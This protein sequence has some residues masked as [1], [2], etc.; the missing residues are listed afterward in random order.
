MSTSVGRSLTITYDNVLGYFSGH[1]S[2][3]IHVNSYSNDQIICLSLGD[4]SGGANLTDSAKNI[5]FP[6]S[7]AHPTKAEMTWLVHGI[8]ATGTA[9]LIINGDTVLSGNIPNGD[10]TLTGSGSGSGVKSATKSSTISYELT[11][12]TATLGYV[13]CW[14]GS[15][16]G[17]LTLY[18]TR[19]DYSASRGTGISLAVPLSKSLV[20]GSVSGNTGGYS[21][22][23]NG[24]ISYT[25]LDGSSCVA[26][27]NNTA[28]A[29]P[30]GAIIEGTSLT[31]GKQYFYKVEYN[32]PV[33]KDIRIGM[34]RT[35]GGNTENVVVTGTGAWKTICHVFTATSDMSGQIEVVENGPDSTQHTWYTRNV[36]IKDTDGQGYDGDQL[37]FYA[38]VQD[39]YKW[40][41]WYSGDTKVSSNQ[42][43]LRNVA[44]SDVSLQARAVPTTKRL[45]VNYGGANVIDQQVTPP[46]SVIY[47]GTEIASINSAE[48]K[49]LNILKGGLPK[50]LASPIIIGDKKLSDTD[51]NGRKW[52]FEHNIVISIV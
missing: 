9:K 36:T 8:V 34:R 43:Y 49:T 44:G 45:T 1:G 38:E 31:V 28:N 15:D 6:N 27:T 20:P 29:Y 41:G 21:P 52:I 46:V 12:A 40:D 5:L 33:G 22:Y 11:K 32:A 47:D 50:I 39:G 3:K 14:K 48:T 18:F 26:I 10:V 17:P 19:Y 23:Y 42:Y 13:G 37:G 24:S 7:T 16:I 35:N 51:S 2:A 30:D 25:T 4:K